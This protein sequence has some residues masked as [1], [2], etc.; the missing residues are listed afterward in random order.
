MAI[1]AVSLGLR[2]SEVLGLQWK[3]VDWLNHRLAVEQRIYR[4]HVDSTK[5]AG[6]SAE[7]HVDVFLRLLKAWHQMSQFQGEEDW[8]FASPIQLGRPPGSAPATNCI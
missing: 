2:A 5:T 1:L 3:H 4:Q 6:S 7:L 8:M